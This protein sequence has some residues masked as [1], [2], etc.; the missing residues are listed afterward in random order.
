V[1]GAAPSARASQKGGAVATRISVYAATPVCGK[2]IG[3]DQ[4]SAWFGQPASQ[5]Y[6]LSRM[7]AT[8]RGSSPGKPWTVA[9]RL[10]NVG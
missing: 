10:V 5:R 2:K 3:G 7:N 9:K 4:K 6:E 1:S 8:S